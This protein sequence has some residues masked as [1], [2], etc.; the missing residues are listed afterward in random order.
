MICF[1]SNTKAEMTTA[2]IYVRKWISLTFDSAV[3]HE[4]I[5]RK[6]LEPQFKACY[7]INI[8]TKKKKHFGKLTE[9][10]NFDK[11]RPNTGKHKE[12]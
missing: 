2:T 9:K 8:S 10:Q 4:I 12:S 7:S 6:L 1:I 5:Y 11:I 3:Y